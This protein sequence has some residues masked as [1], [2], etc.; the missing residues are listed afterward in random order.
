MMEIA[1]RIRI[2]LDELGVTQ[3]EL[4]DAA[5]VTPGAVSQWLSRKNPTQISRENLGKIA[6][7]LGTTAAWLEHGVGQGPARSEEDERDDYRRTVLWRYK[8]ASPEGKDFGNSNI[9]SLKPGIGSIAREPSQNSND[10]S[11]GEPVDLTYRLIT[12]AGKELDD[13]LAALDWPGL[14]S[15]IGAYAADGHKTS[16]ILKAGLDYVE[17]ARAGG[18]LLLLV[19]EDRRTT[20]LLGDEFL[21]GNFAALCRDNLNSH[22]ASATAGGS[23]G[24]GKSVLWRSS[25]I[26]TVLFNSDLKSP[27]EE[28]DETGE[29]HLRQETRVFGRTELG[30]HQLGGEE[31]AGTGYFGEKRSVK[32]VVLSASKWSNRTLARDLYLSRDHLGGDAGTSIGVVAFHDPSGK[33]EGLP[34]VVETLKRELAR[35]F[36][37]AIAAGRLN[38][39]VE[40]AKGR[41]TIDRVQVD[42]KADF[43]GMVALYE[44]YLN[45]T[46]DTDLDGV[47]AMVSR[48]VSLRVP[49]RRTGGQF[50][51]HGSIAHDAVVLVRASDLADTE[52][53]LVHMFRGP[54]MVVVS[55][56]LK[57]V[58]GVRLFQAAVLVGEAV[59]AIAPDVSAAEVFLRAAEPPAH[60]DWESTP[61]LAVEYKRGGGENIRAFKAAVVKTIRE[62]VMPEVKD[63]DDGPAMLKRLLRI[64]GS[65]TPPTSMPQVTDAQSSIVTDGHWTVK[66]SV[67]VP[68]ITQRWEGRLVPIAN[69][70]SGGGDALK[71]A[72]VKAV[73][74]CS[75]RQKGAD[76][77]LIIPPGMREGVFEGV[78]D[79]ESHLVPP[80]QTTLTVDFRTL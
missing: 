80:D 19:I 50:P 48:T 31:Y 5:E 30:Y 18:E 22:K 4:A 6:K 35:S 11:Q 3:A 44:A 55:E 60:D 70:E 21:P 27:I 39:Y 54:G 12:L 15:H 42:P 51:A 53:N 7:K 25:R 24:L 34:Q 14:S 79:P 77:Y 38:V 33:V 13:F 36:W 61:D 23:Y 49:E 37:P 47:G 52:P 75:V 71:W 29:V 17:A 16:R 10:L 41:A 40:T 26:G 72:R 74:G 66:A 57:D 59:G 76:W 43:A 68:R 46:L 67:R 2:A 9:F 63:L 73:K 65:V 78:T 58:P 64:A 8:K 1:D 20:G 28:I 45:G 69:K 62:L 32:G 56:S